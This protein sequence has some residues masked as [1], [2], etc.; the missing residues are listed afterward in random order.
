MCFEWTVCVCVCVR[1]LS[2]SAV[3]NSVTVA[4]QA[5]LGFPR[6]EDWSGLPFPSPGHRPW[7]RNRTHFSCVSCTGRQILY[8]CVIWSL[9]CPLCYSF[10]FIPSLLK[11][12][13]AKKITHT[14]SVHY[15]KFFSTKYF[16]KPINWCCPFSTFRERW[17]Q[18]LKAN[19][20]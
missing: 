5:P 18:I 7:P 17:F 4:H 10:I 3:S 15:L 2:W 11:Y 1:A 9:A 19:Y 14:V 12:R 6:P 16:F 13:S 20:Q 8:H